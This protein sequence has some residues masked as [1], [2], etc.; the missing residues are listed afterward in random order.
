MFVQHGR[1]CF[2]YHFPLERHEIRG[3]AP[4]T[5]GDHTIAW[6][7]T[8]LDRVSGRGELAVDGVVAGTVD[9]PRI[10]RGWMPFGGMNVGCDNG[11]PVATS[12]EAPFRFTGTL[13]RIEVRL[14]GADPG[15]D[16]AAEHRSEMGKQ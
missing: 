6:T 11:A 2:H 10:I 5:P 12:Y 8:K 3:A 9:I 14:L 4:L 7:L 15:P 1:P 13:H 16:R